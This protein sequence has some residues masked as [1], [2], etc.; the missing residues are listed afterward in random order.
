MNTDADQPE[1]DS[2]NLEHFVGILDRLTKAG[3]VE[4]H[5]YLKDAHIIKFTN[6]GW[7]MVYGI[8]EIEDAGILTTTED[9][10]VVWEIFRTARPIGPSGINR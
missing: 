5:G 3:F 8:R 7:K 10:R 6:K 1:D 9:R 2:Q 4:E